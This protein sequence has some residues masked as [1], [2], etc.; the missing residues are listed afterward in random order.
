MHCRRAMTER[1]PVQLEHFYTPWQRWFE[2]RIYPAKDGGLSVFSQEVSA[3]K[4]VEEEIRKNNRVLESANEDLKQFAYSISHDLREPLR[5]VYSFCQLLHQSYTGKI[6][7]KADEIIGYCLAAARR[8]DALI[9]DL[10]SYMHAASAPKEILEPISVGPAVEASLL[11][12]QTAIEESGANV[13]HDPMPVI[14]MAPVHAQQIFQ[15][16]ISNALKYR[17]SA[18]PKVHVGARKEGRAWIF[19]VQDNGVGIQPEY[20]SYVFGLF[21]R[22]HA[23][24]NRSGTGIGLALCKKLVERYGG[25]IWVE[26]EPGKGSTFFFSV[27]TAS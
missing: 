6:D 5:N 25:E 4:Q 12:L 23:D 2:I 22:L 16:L 17:G 7:P 21:T 19:S 3:R 8:M 27:P 9:N 26:S 10:L 1:I 18:A 11:N 24:R 13:T 20:Q 14:R 15:N